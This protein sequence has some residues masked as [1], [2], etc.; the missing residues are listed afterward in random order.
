MTSPMEW[1][2]RLQ[3]CARTDPSKLPKLVEDIQS[4]AAQ[5][6]YSRAM[7]RATNAV[8]QSRDRMDRALTNALTVR[9]G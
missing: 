6:G 2:A 8:A 9:A 4:E 1:A 3:E 7:F 5:L